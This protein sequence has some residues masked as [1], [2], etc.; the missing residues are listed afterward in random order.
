MPFRCILDTELCGVDL[1]VNQVLVN[2]GGEGRV[3]Y[4]DPVVGLDR[5]VAIFTL[6]DMTTFVLAWVLA[7]TEVQVVR[8]RAVPIQG[9]KIVSVNLFVMAV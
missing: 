3:K 9:E 4:G 6:D 1:P 8:F 5:I 2:F 7:I